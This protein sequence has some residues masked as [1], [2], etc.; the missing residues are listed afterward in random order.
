MADVKWIKITTDIFSDEKILLIESMPDAYA[1][2][3]CWF[4]LLCLAGQ[5]NNSGVF[6]LNNKIAYTDEMLAT[7]FRMPLN[8]VRL[9]LSTFE[10]FGMVELIDGVI[11]I[12]NWSKHQSVDRIE[13]YNAYM[14]N[15]MQE[16]RAKQKSI[17]SGDVNINSKI[18][19]KFN[20]NNTDKD[21]DKDKDKKKKKNNIKHQYGEF[22]NVLLTD[23]EYRKL[24]EKF[25][26]YEEKIENLSYYMASHKTDY[27]SHYATILNW[28][29]KDVKEQE[30]R[31][32]DSTR[33][34]SF[35]GHDDK[36]LPF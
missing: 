3:V 10:Q 11:T 27:K 22:S 21:I 16:Y 14:R 17:A 29:R 2:I 28:A 30:Q 34:E 8:T 25:T 15:Y 24:Q 36:E 4:K 33:Y 32:N 7:I 35:F 6:I 18:N 19:S 13:K 9:A 26:D 5:M 31:K 12:P 20:V 1:I 23:D